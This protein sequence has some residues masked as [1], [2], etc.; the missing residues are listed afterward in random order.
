MFDLETEKLV[1]SHGPAVNESTP[2][3]ARLVCT[4][5]GLTGGVPTEPPDVH[6]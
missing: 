2:E 3:G 4:A 1:V 6:R 5:M